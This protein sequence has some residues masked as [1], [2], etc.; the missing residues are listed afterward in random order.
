MTDKLRQF[1]IVFTIVSLIVMNAL[2]NTGAF[3][4]QTNGDISAKY[5]TLITPA[6]YAFSI[7]GLIFLGLLIFAVYQALPAQA[8]NRRF[9]AAGPWIILNAI[10]NAIWSPIF[11]QEWIGLALL[12][13]LV[14]FFSLLMVVEK[15]EINPKLD[16][17]DPA[18]TRETWLAR[19][20]FLLYFGWLT[21][22]TI[23]NITV[24]LKA[25]N[26]PLSGLPESTWAEAVLVVG[27]VVGTYLFNRYRSIAYILVFAWAYAAIAVKQQANSGVLIIAGAG[28]VIAVGLAIAGL[29]SRRTPNVA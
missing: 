23:L 12:V 4:G 20:P 6:G 21:V 9:R 5:S 2:S 29:L 8:T 28:A 11:N 17:P 13:I 1:L 3:G 14:M 24:Y 25:S 7:W 10:C 15:L 26:F 19:I 22:A 16:L 18:P 27:L